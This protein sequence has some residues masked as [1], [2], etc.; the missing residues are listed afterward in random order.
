MDSNDLS[1]GPPVGLHS[2]FGTARFPMGERDGEPMHGET[3]YT[4]P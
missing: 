3:T 4:D 2:K 1:V